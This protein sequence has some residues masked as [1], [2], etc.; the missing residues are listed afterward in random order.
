[1]AALGI[2]IDTRPGAGIR[3]SPHPCNTEQECDRVIDELARLT[4]R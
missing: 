1:M 4:R 2:D 3:V